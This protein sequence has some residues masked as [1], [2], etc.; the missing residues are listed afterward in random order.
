MNLFAYEVM[1]RSTMIMKLLD[2]SF[3]EHPYIVEKGWCENDYFYKASVINS[4]FPEGFWNEMTNRDLCVCLKELVDNYNFWLEEF[5]D[6]H[7][8]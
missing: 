5:S 1:E 7:L 2:S 4:K 6:E 3:A 8:I